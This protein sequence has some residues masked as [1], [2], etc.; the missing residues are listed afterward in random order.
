MRRHAFDVSTEQIGGSMP[1]KPWLAWVAIECLACAPGHSSG[2]ITEWEL[3]TELAPG[4][5]GGRLKVP[6]T[7]QTLL[8]DRVKGKIRIRLPTPPANQL[9][10]IPQRGG[11]LKSVLIVPMFATGQQHPEFEYT[12]SG[13]SFQ[14]ILSAGKVLSGDGMK[15]EGGP[16]VHYLIYTTVRQRYRAS[17]L[18]ADVDL[19]LK[20]GWNV[21]DCRSAF[22]MGTNMRASQRPASSIEVRTLEDTSARWWPTLKVLSTRSVNRT[23]G[24]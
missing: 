17:H 3:R 21:I 22:V 7:F 12:D 24:H 19:S 4:S 2:N 23:G 8:F 18:L 16:T 9:A 11:V 20:P 1:M 15:G 5:D 13:E 14:A 6:I 10:D